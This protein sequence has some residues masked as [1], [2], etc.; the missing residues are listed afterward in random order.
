LRVFTFPN[1]NPAPG[2]PDELRITLC[3]NCRHEGQMSWHEL[4]E[5]PEEPPAHSCGFCGTQPRQCI[6]GCSDFAPC[7]AGCYFVDPALTDGA[8]VCSVVYAS[9]IRSAAAR[10]ESLILTD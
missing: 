7:E 4:T 5:R 3:L 9:A 6:C 1:P 2:R 8:D 10:P